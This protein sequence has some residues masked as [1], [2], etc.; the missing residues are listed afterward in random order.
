MTD[1]TT[2]VALPITVQVVVDGGQ[3]YAI[4]G[5]GAQ[6][7]AESCHDVLVQAEFTTDDGTAITASLDGWQYAEG[8]GIYRSLTLEPADT[9]N[10]GSSIAVEAPEGARMARFVIRPG[11]DEC[12]T[13]EIKHLSI[14]NGRTI[15][16]SRRDP[17]V[18]RYSVAEGNSYMLSGAYVGPDTGGRSPALVSVDFL[19]EDGSQIPG[20]YR[21]FRQSQHDYVGH[22]RYLPVPN[23]SGD[24]PFALPLEPPAGSHS[25]L[26][27]FMLWKAEHP[28]SLVAEPLLVQ[29]HS[30]EHPR[31]ARKDELLQSHTL[32]VEGG[33]RY[34]ITGSCTDNLQNKRAVLVTVAFSDANG[35]PIEF[36]LPGWRNSETLGVNRY[37]AAEVVGEDGKTFNVYVD[38]PNSARTMTLNFLRWSKIASP[39]LNDVTVRLV[40]DH[41][42]GLTLPLEREYAIGGGQVY[43]LRGACVSGDGGSQQ[44]VRFTVDFLDKAKQILSGPWDY[45]RWSTDPSIGSFQER[46]AGEGP[47]GADF[48]IWLAPPATAERIRVRFSANN[49]M[50]PLNLR[51]E[52]TLR[53]V[54]AADIPEADRLCHFPREINLPIEGGSRFRIHGKCMSE[55]SA[56]PRAGLLTIEF[57]DE[58]GQRVGPATPEQRPLQSA[59]VSVGGLPFIYSV[60]APDNARNMT[61]RFAQWTRTVLYLCGDVRIETERR[62]PLLPDRILVREYLVSSGHIY[63][64]S[65]ACFGSAA[66]T[67]KAGIVSVSFIDDDG[68]I[69]PGRYRHLSYSENFHNYRYIDASDEGAGAPFVIWLEPPASARKVRLVF[70]RWQVTSDEWIALTDEPRFEKIDADRA[71]TW[72]ADQIR[73]LQAQLP[74][75]ARIGEL[76]ACVAGHKRVFQVL[77]TSQ[78]RNAYVNTASKLRELDPKWLPFHGC[79]QVATRTDSHARICHLFKVSYPFESS[80][81]AIRNLN[82]VKFQRLI[83]LDPYVITPLGYPATQ[84]ITEFSAEEEIDGVPHIRLPLHGDDNSLPQ[85]SRLSYDAYVTAGVIAA[86][87]ADV[88]HAASG[89]RGYELALKGLALKKQFGLPAVYEVRS[90]H[91]H[92]WGRDSSL[93]SEWTQLRIAQENRCMHESDAVVTIA[94]TMRDLLIERGI[95]SAK[96]HVVPNGVDESKFIPMMPDLELKSSLG[97]AGT[98]IVGYISNLS[99]REGHSV[100]LHAL[101]RLSQTREYVRCL[102]VGDGPSRKALEDLADSLGVRDKVVMTGEVD[103]A[104][105]LRY[106]SIIDVFVVPRQPDYASDFVT[107]LK[108][109]EAMAM[110]R[111]V[112]VSD[113]PSLREIVGDE[114]R[115]LIFRTGDA[116]HLAALLGELVDRPE[117]RRALGEAAR[118]WILSERTWKRLVSRYQEIYRTIIG[119]G[120]SGESGQ[121][122]VRPYSPVEN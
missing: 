93:E 47:D 122:A 5:V 48:A 76:V 58:Y 109:F 9:P 43:A 25:V 42:G 71:A 4:S 29:T 114:E 75:I 20:P 98:T 21:H 92:L 2:G 49:P 66:H 24:T 72:P 31:S 103:H 80:G 12:A 35:N 70:D 39:Q 100:L 41:P 50:V 116:E 106:Y 120:I 91:E 32:D 7:A 62:I 53:P 84:G 23:T 33:Q 6:A 40:A 82:I 3:C 113:R 15:D 78:A 108:P 118:E 95:P 69:L 46:P 60:E 86:R 30:Q 8:L 10:G 28:I 110:E 83:G 37:I 112:V 55:G 102:F 57:L 17:T 99:S 34:I 77:R 117:L 74:A 96:I 38:C 85:H 88:I 26:A 63:A 89:Y 104:S 18:R 56:S 101:Q 79:H 16:L 45:L 59:P 107:P 105:I 1:N 27:R 119:R 14:T 87:G 51:E 52:P 68:Q 22:Y 61:L 54:D 13:I 73:D 67:D 65:G 121:G 97:L 19:G 11:R 94:E 44:T 81:G 64:V 115:G 90:L 36:I 111:A